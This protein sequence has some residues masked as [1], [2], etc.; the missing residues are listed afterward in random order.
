MQE[1]CKLLDGLL[2]PH[3]LKFRSV[4]KCA[5]IEECCRPSLVYNHNQCNKNAQAPGD[6]QAAPKAQC[7]L[8]KVFQTSEVSEMKSKAI[9]H[10]NDDPRV[11]GLKLCV[12]P[13][14][15]SCILKD[16]V[17]IKLINTCP[18]DNYL[19]IFYLHLLN[20]PNVLH[21]LR[22]SPAV[23]AQCLLDVV[24]P[25]N[26]KD[27]AR[28]KMHWLRQFP[29]YDFSFSS[30]VDV[31]GC[32]QD[33]VLPCLSPTLS[34]KFISTCDSH[35]CPQKEK[36]IKSAS[37][38]LLNS[39]FELGANNPLKI[40]LEHWLHQ[41]PHACSVKFDAPAP[42]TAVI[43]E[44]EP[45]LV[46]E[47]HVWEQSQCCGGI[48]TSSNREFDN[49]LPWAIPLFVGQMLANAGKCW[50]MLAN[51]G[52]LQHPK[53]L[54][55]KFT[56]NNTEYYIGGLTFWN[57]LHFTGRVQSDGYWYDY[58]GLNLNNLIKRVGDVTAPTPVGYVI[59]SCVYFKESS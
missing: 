2:G 32:E 17:H 43:R 26:N 36:L 55:S 46:L 44:G 19:T 41:P 24:A 8:E 34:N 15:G 23:Y 33:M 6:S 45:Y 22:L 29:K 18:I 31:W 51:A 48:H 37:I 4:N 58:D 9:I 53:E 20:H 38:C 56:I 30:T 54:P 35:H 21:E 42:E 16:H 50:Q 57:G 40:L 13:W 3:K 52:K 5:V 59:S 14:G 25:F 10:L 27:F 49:G 12:P 11:E 1:T 47:D 28:G 7:S 39:A